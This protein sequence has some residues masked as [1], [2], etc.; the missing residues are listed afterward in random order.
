MNADSEV[1][2]RVGYTD[3]VKPEPSEY[4]RLGVLDVFILRGEAR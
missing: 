2:R 3:A 4:L 1:L